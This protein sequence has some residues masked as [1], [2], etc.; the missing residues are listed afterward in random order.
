MDNRDSLDRSSSEL[1][2]NATTNGGPVIGTGPE[3]SGDG[4]AVSSTAAPTNEPL[5]VVENVLQSDVRWKPIVS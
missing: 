5:Q 1:G 4:Y 2:T 3:D